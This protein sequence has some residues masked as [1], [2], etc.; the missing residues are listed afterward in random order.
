MHVCSR[1]K[2]FQLSIAVEVLWA[3]DKVRAQGSRQKNWI[4]QHM[5]QG[6]S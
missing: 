5:S 2:L 6:E 4:K 3:Y 1:E